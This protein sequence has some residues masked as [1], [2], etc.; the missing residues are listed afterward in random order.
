MDEESAQTPISPQLAHILHALPNGQASPL[1]QI[2]AYDAVLI[3]YK[4]T[5]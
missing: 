4:N 3:R 1:P 5:T 2:R